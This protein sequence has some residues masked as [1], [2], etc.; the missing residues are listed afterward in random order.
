[1][2]RG[3]GGQARDDQQG[4]GQKQDAHGVRM[5]GQ[6]VKAGHQDSVSSGV[7]ARDRPARR[8]ATA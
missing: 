7:S 1:M 4:G 6:A 3:A 5:S 2:V 8:A